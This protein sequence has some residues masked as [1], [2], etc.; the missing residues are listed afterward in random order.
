[1][2]KITV[3]IT[4]YNSFKYLEDAIR[5][6]LFDNRVSEIIILDDCSNV[7]QFNFLKNKIKS[8]KNGE[9]ISNDIHYNFIDTK[10]FSYKSN[11]EYLTMKSVK[12]LAKK[13]SIY[14]NNK[15]LGS[16]ISKYLAV[17]KSNNDWVYLLDGDNFL[18]DSSISAIFNLKKWNKKICYLPSTLITNINKKNTNWDH[19]NFRRF[20][21][22]KINL[23]EMQRLFLLEDSLIIKNKAGIGL[24]GLLNN[25]NFFINKNEYLNCLKKPLKEKIN[26]EAADAAAFI[27]YWLINKKEIKVV[28]ELYYFHRIRNDSLWQIKNKNSYYE[29]L[30]NKIL[31]SIKPIKDEIIGSTSKLTPFN[32]AIYYEAMI[33]NA[34]IS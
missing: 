13:I 17:K 32:K 16:F 33:R 23:K 22:Q 10:Y 31:K 34:K 27:Y 14:R 7:K 15:N 1:V 5:I 26:P 20:C 28:P 18:I 3:A 24:N 19:W 8:L 9:K 21:N 30:K 6:P 29:R 25:G 11:I 4:F 12:N 2:K